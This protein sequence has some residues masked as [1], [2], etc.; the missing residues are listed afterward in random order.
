MNVVGRVESEGAEVARDDDQVE[1][2][3][4]A[5]EENHRHEGTVFQD[6]GVFIKS[7][8]VPT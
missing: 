4:Q 2:E 1:A 5:D 7:P 3:T 6:Y 8:D